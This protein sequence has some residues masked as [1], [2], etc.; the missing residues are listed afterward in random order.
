MT[1]KEPKR[2]EDAKGTADASPGESAASPH[3]VDRTAGTPV[4]SDPGTDRGSRV[5]SSV[6]G[7]TWVGLIIG[8]VILVLLLVFILQ[9]GDPVRLHMFAWTWNF[10]IGVGMLIAAVAGALIAASVGTVRIMQ[11]RHQVRS[12]K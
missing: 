8:A 11:L 10:P 6:A 9:N 4:P 3:P 2:P 7:S 12:T 5:I 1:N